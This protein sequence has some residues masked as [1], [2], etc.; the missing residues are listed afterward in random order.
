MIDVNA[1]DFS[2]AAV[3]LQM[4][5]NDAVERGDKEALRFLEDNATATVMRKID[6][7]KEM[8]EDNC[9]EVTKPVTMYRVEY[10]TK[11]CGYVVK[12]Y[13]PSDEA[14]A[15]ARERAKAKAKKERENL[16]ANA[17]AALNK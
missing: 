7:E 5:V 12:K 14:K 11:Y 3:T 8:T 10:L 6:K 9:R 13:A 4:M 1:K 17:F 15:K 2:L 16:F